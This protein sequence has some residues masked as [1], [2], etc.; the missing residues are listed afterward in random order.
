MVSHSESVALPTVTAD[1]NDKGKPSDDKGKGRPSDEKA[2]AGK[3]KKPE[4]PFRPTLPKNWNGTC[5]C[6]RCM[7][8]H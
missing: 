7:S 4:I 8:T 5:L 6:V 2:N 1:G 3:K